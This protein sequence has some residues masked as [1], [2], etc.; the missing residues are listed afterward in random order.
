DPL[1]KKD[2][3]IIYQVVAEPDNLHPTNGISAMRQE[4]NY[5]IHKSLMQTDYCTL[6]A[7]PCLVKTMPEISADYIGYTYELRDEPTWD[8]GQQLSVE[9]I[10]FTCKAN[11]CWLTNNPNGKPYWDNVM[12]IEIDS[13]N[14]RKFT[15]IMKQAY[16]QNVT[17]WTDYPVMQRSF[18]DKD[19]LLLNFSVP[20]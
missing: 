6:K 12:D 14:K 1:W 17:M 11:K 19:D 3:T 10:I 16:I 18:Y 15:V 4:L 20:E 9:D 8:N 5:Y 7:I 13:L 2:N